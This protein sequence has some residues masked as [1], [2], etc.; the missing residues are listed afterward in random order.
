MNTLIFGHDQEV[1]SW[2][3]DRIPYVNSFEPCTAIGVASCGRLIAGVVYNEYSPQAQNLQISIA[4]DSPMWARRETISALLHY[5]FRQLDCWMVFSL[6]Q[7][8]NARSLSVCKHIGFKQKTIVPHAFGKK[9]HAVVFQMTEPE[10]AKLY[11]VHHGQV[12]A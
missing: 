6:I 3:A 7:P 12:V 5:P 2:V 8:D 11:E 9:R 4:A 10:Y 1:A